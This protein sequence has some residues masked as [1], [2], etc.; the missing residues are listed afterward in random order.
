MGDAALRL[1]GL[2]DLDGAQA[3][4]TALAQRTGNVFSTWEW[5]ETWWRHFGRGRTVAL[6][7]ALDGAGDVRVV[8]PLCRERRG[9]VSV[10]RFL[11]GGVGD[12]LGP[13]CDPADAAAAAT[14][15][16]A[17]IGRRVLLAERLPAERDWA[18]A[19]GG[20]ALKT[21]ASPIL[22]LAG[23]GGWEGYLAGRSANFRQE[24]R[25]RQRRLER[26]GVRYRLSRDPRDLEPMMS[27]HAARWNGR[28][29]A[30]AGA[31]ADFHREF[32]ARALRAGWLRLWL[33]EADGAPV[34]AWYG[35]RFGTVESYYSSGRDPAW[36]RYR[37]GAGIL[38]H[39]IREAFADGMHEYRFLRGGEA[40]KFR[41]TDSD[42][43][44]CTVLAARGAAG[45]ALAETVSVTVRT[46]AGRELLKRLA[47]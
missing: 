1:V 12:Q 19:L 5:A 4:W 32:A 39:S 40:Y 9:G 20:R 21:E 16:R 8:L 18:R 44:V 17:A 6:L 11:G 26:V 38:E 23:A 28:S 33:A 7:G 43:A 31:R 47:G 25:R 10:L 36:D 14:A 37:L 15:L 35:F 22:P 46:R 13:V 45:R 41:Y 24:V 3:A 29:R 34:A 30:F 27:L 2:G 42:A